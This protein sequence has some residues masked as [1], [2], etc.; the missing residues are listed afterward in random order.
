M[1]ERAIREYDGKRLLSRNLV[2]HAASESDAALL[3]LAFTGCPVLQVTG[4]NPD[5]AALAASAPWVHTSKLVAKPDQLI[6]RRGKGG[7]LLLNADWEAA[8]AWVAGKNGTDVEVDSVTGR[9]NTFLVEPFVPHAP[10]DEYYICINSVR[11]GEAIL[12]THEGGIDVG[13]VDAK[14]AKL[15]V[16]I[17]ET[18]DAAA[19]EAAL[20]GAVPASRRPV[21]VAF[22]GA[23]F[24]MY[25]AL[26]YVYLEI[27]PLVLLDAPAA[28][29]VPSIVPLDM[30]AKLDEAAAFL[31]G[32]KWGADLAFP[33]PFGR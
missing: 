11:E 2:D 15:M 9:L 17:G 24:R 29:G 16:P 12:F 18:P 22:V 6:K 28:G 5:F 21:L 31:A 3:R 26:H 1:A 32:A 10:S 25:M 4:A 27:N 13:D 20:L 23:L 8:S 14:A 19:I 33:P 30:A 7:L